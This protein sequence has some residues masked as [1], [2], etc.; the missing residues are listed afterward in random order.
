MSLLGRVSGSA[1]R[2]LVSGELGSQ[3]G[4]WRGAGRG[5]P[6]PALP[7]GGMNSLCLCCASALFPNDVLLP[8]KSLPWL[9]CPIE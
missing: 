3:G 7:Q 2:V 5:D 6:G 9:P 4:H 8:L 1:L